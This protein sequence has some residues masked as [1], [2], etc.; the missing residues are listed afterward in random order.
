[1]L[2]HIAGALSQALDEPSVVLS[3]GGASGAGVIDANMAAVLLSAE[4][5]MTLFACC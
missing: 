3:E 1:M 4:G 2:C 5:A